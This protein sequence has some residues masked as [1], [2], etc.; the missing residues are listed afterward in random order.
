MPLTPAI[1]C[2]AVA[3]EVASARRR[4]SS[5]VLLDAL[6]LGTLADALLHEGPGLGL[7]VWM[8]AFAVVL[9]HLVH[10]RGARLTREHVG[11]LAAAVFFAGSFAWRDSS[12]LRFYNFLAMLAALALLGATLSHASPMRSILGQRVRDVARALGRVAKD[13]ASSVVILALG[14]AELG[15]IPP[16][17]RTGRIRAAMSASLIALPLLVVFGILFSA[18]D[19][20]FGALFALPKMNL[21]EVGSHLAIAG[22]FTWVVGGWL[23]GAVVDDSAPSSRVS[24][25]VITL[26]ALDVT[27]IL[28]G[29]VALFALFVGVQIGWLFGGER[30]VRSTTGLGYAQY[31]RHG[32]FEL[33]WVSLLVLPVLLG[34]RASLRH[35]DAAAERRHRLLA[36]PLIGLVGGVM[37]SALG[38]MGLYVHYYGLS[39]DR[40]FASVFMGWLAIVFAWLGLT[41]LRGRSRDFAAGM[42]VTGFLTIA[43]L[44]FA[45]P[46]ALVARVNIARA[47]VAPT[48]SDSVLP[49]DY[50][51]LASS[52]DGDAVG[53]VIRALVAP[54]VL[55]ATSRTRALE[56]RA[57]CDAVKTLFTRWQENV[58]VEFPHQGLDWRLWSAA[59][60]RA[61]SAVRS[62]EKAL[63]GVTCWDAGGEAAFGSRE[64]RRP[65]PGEQW[66]VMPRQP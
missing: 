11:W 14:D 34:T 36:V 9:R 1:E 17:W 58:P 66:Y 48:L 60:W 16:A 63:R 41:V 52:L 30:L 20:M 54:P 42:T 47:R 12:G 55:P 33:V 6:F 28:G 64:W 49:I 10:Q 23:R 21:G 51:Y 19:P 56:V 45:N 62:Q 40:L 53:Y 39:T 27:I 2:A 61:R 18:A 13:A 50:S 37:A 29:L 35:G 5:R 22:F 31:A 59:A 24:R 26:G 65:V 57:R 3:P 15:D 7:L 32:F 4:F 25:A 38:R 44:N 8:A 46:D 43:M